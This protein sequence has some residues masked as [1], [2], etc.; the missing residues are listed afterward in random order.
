MADVAI[1]GVTVP[2]D[3]TV[4]SRP[5]LFGTRGQLRPDGNGG[6]TS[7][8][9]ADRP[10][11]ATPQD[12]GIETGFFNGERGLPWHVALSFQLGQNALMKDAGRLLTAREATA[13]GGPAGSFEVAKVPIF[14]AGGAGPIE[15]PGVFATTRTDTGAPLGVVGDRYRVFQE[16]ELGEFA[17]YVVDQ[18]A[19]LTPLCETGGHMRDGRLFFLSLEL[20]G[21]DIIVP[22]DPSAL[23][24]YLLLVTSHDGSMPVSFYVTQVRT[25]CRNTMRLAT[26]KA[27]S[28]FRIR[29]TGS[30]EGKVSEARR[31][32]GI[33]LKTAESV[34]TLT[35]RLA[36]KDVVDEQV[37][38]IFAKAWPIDEAK[39]GELLIERQQAHR[40]QAWELYENSPTLE[41]VDHSAW[42][43]VQAGVEHVDFGSKFRSRKRMDDSDARADALLWGSGQETKERLVRAALEIAK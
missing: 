11:Y 12:S 35:E 36:L 9:L 19:H 8:M 17:D 16:R 41:G 29:H 14:I 34:K 4:E 30:L 7:M 28:S 23:Q 18:G 26:Q 13:P 25:V 40:D 24:T 3:A 10:E 32:L 27:A 20:K 22:G 43:A 2:V 21:L 42:R 39:D 33:T 38:A 15:I 31:A 5:D 1:E 37:R 6:M